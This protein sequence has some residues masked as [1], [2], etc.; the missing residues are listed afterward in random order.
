[1]REEGQGV[2]LIVIWRMREEGEEEG[3]GVSV[4][5]RWRKGR[6]RILLRKGRRKE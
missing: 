3:L 5:E 2:S 1:M 4:S 6:G